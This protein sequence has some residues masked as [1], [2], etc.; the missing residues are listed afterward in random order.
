[1]S[2]SY[3][4]HPGFK[5]GDRKKRWWKRQAN[6][7]I[8]RTQELDDGKSYRKVYDQW[9]ICDWNWRYYSKSE[10]KRDIEKWSW[11]RWKPYKYWI[12]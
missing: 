3:K 4:K 10:A 11:G 8:R 9:K 2:R 7:K 5:D 1:M 12:K 6:K